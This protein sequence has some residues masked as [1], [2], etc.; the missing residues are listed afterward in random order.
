MLVSDGD[1]RSDSKQP[2][3]F[4]RDTVGGSVQQLSPE[5]FLASG[6]P[7]SDGAGVGDQTGVVPAGREGDDG[8]DFV[9][10][11][12]LSDVAQ[13]QRASE[14]RGDQREQ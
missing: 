4:A 3:D 13:H 12:H 11:R 5:N 2:F 1:V 14:R 9:S 8:F 6:S 7:T 10:G